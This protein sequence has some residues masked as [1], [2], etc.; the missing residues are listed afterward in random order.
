MLIANTLSEIGRRLA[1]YL[2]RQDQV[3]REAADQLA[4]AEALAGGSAAPVVDAPAP[5]FL[6][7]FLANVLNPLFHE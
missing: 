1:L 6:T 5:A 4:G 7:E 3:A 2:Y